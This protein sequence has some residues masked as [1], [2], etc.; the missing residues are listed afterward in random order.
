MCY[1]RMKESSVTLQVSSAPQAARSRERVLKS[2]ELAPI[3]I[4]AEEVSFFM[5]ASRRQQ[6]PFV[7]LYLFR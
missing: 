3:K 5:H 7:I 1:E 6:P 4:C 2:D